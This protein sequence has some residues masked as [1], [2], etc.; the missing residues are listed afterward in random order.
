MTTITPQAIEDRR[1]A[2]HEELAN[3]QT[4]LD[5]VSLALAEGDAAAS[6][7]LESLERR[8][9]ALCAEL[10]GLA[11][12][13]R[14]AARRK[15]EEAES[16]RKERMRIGLNEA[17]ALHAKL[18]TEMDDLHAACIALQL[19]RS[20]IITTAQ[21]LARRLSEIDPRARRAPLELQEFTP[22]AI[23]MLLGHILAELG[24][25]DLD[26]RAPALPDRQTTDALVAMR[27]KAQLRAF[28][29]TS[30]S[31][32]ADLRDAAA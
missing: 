16:A 11:A 27:K 23:D 26:I 31:V 1:E 7:R 12:A 10:D 6:T 21:T 17:E 18:K 20:K 24:L 8:K 3:L 19:S 5:T 30:E 32:L 2:I 29:A 4:E 25:R 22:G 13:S 28:E 14:G 9:R 15:A